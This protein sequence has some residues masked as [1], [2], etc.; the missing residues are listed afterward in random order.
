MTRKIIVAALMLAAFFTAGIAD[1]VHPFTVYNAGVECLEEEERLQIICS[2]LNKELEK[3]LVFSNGFSLTE[4]E[5]GADLVLKSSISL[6]GELLSLNTKFYLRGRSNITAQSI[7][8]EQ[9]Y[10][11]RDSLPYDS[12]KALVGGGKIKLLAVE[13]EEEGENTLITGRLFNKLD[14]WVEKNKSSALSAPLIIKSP[15]AD[16]RLFTNGS[17]A[18]SIGSSRT[19]S[20]DIIEGRHDIRIEKDFF[21][22]QTF[23]LN[24]NAD[25][26]MEFSLSNW[27]PGILT[28]ES[29]PG[30][31][32]ITL[33][34]ISAGKT[35]AELTAQSG[36]HE[37]KL[38]KDGRSR[39]AVVFVR[40]NTN[41]YAMLKVDGVNRINAPDRG[42]NVLIA[43]LGFDNPSEHAG[44]AAIPLMNAG[45]RV[46]TINVTDYIPPQ[47]YSELE[48]SSYYSFMPPLAGATNE[49][50][51][52]EK[53]KTNGDVILRRMIKN[54]VALKENGYDYLFTIYP[55]PRDEGREL[56]ERAAIFETRNF[57]NGAISRFVQKEPGPFFSD[58]KN[59]YFSSMG[60]NEEQTGR[61][62]FYEYVVNSLILKKYP[63]AEEGDISDEDKATVDGDN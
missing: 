26:G 47:L 31:A 10:F 57:K 33:D 8:T 7:F 22:P 1:G 62:A 38:E 32:E 37:I 56:V 18:G 29:E 41:S 2:Q 42:E 21:P 45:I 5:E 59:E 6:S 44:W 58:Y 34:G 43:V 24:V 53:D 20:I 35:P 52:L 14:A 28:I 12:V 39:T 30:G 27:T 60:E 48:S 61:L 50:S 15:V 19:I 40:P 51:F 11:V 3:K 23:T 4:E 49:D 17:P 13:K 46:S 25:E 55:D 36:R 16:A 63:S 9:V 54:N